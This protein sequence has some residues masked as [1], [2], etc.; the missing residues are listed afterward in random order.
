MYNI[1]FTSNIVSKKNVI[2]GI[3]NFTI[4]LSFYLLGNYI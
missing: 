1:I 2:E 4:I 3:K